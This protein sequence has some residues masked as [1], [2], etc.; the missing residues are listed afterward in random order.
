MAHLEKIELRTTTNVSFTEDLNQIR[1]SF[2][3]QYCGLH[4]K[5]RAREMGLRKSGVDDLAHKTFC[6]I[7]HVRHLI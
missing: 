3:S 1:V 4:F 6:N 5:M 7:F 2:E